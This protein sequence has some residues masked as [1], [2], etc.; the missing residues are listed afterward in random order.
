MFVFAAVG[1]AAGCGREPLDVGGGSAGKTGGAGTGG[2][3]GK[4][5]SAGTGA[6]AGNGGASGSGGAAGGAPNPAPA[7]SALDEMSCTTRGDCH[8]SYCG[9][10]GEEMFSSCLGPGEVAPCPAYACPAVPV[11][12]TGLDEATCNA[13]PDCQAGYCSCGSQRTYAGCGAPGTGFFCF[14]GCR[15][16]CAG[17][18]EGT[19]AA[20]GDCD[21]EY[22][23]G[24]EGRAFVGCGEPGAG[25]SCPAAPPSC[26][27]AP[28]SAITDQ[29][30]C[31]ARTDCHSVF[32]R[33]V[34]CLC[35]P[36]GCPVE[37]ARCTD[38]GKAACSGSPICQSPPPD[39]GAGFVAAHNPMCWVGCVRPTECGP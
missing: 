18:D 34:G 22:C 4:G 31:D 9:C 14:D 2:S 13:R 16:P 25:F 17:L 7:C 12:C 37:F 5:G 10:P 28:C 6:S 11:P 8:P 38:G 3:A 30:S 20:R 35:G 23:N 19:C 26:P 29:L 1:G 21:A 32:E 39:C 15:T 27:L 24:C 36:S 33:C